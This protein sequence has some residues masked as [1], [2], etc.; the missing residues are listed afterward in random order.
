ME[1]PV[2]ARRLAFGSWIGGDCDGNPNGT[3]QTTLDV[4]ELRTLH[5]L[6]AAA[7]AVDEL[8]SSA[9]IAGT[10]PELDASLVADLE[11]LP[12]VDSR[13][14]CLNAEE[15]YGLTLTCLREKLGRTRN[16]LA[17]EPA[18]ARPRLRRHARF[19]G[20][21]PGQRGEVIARG[22]LERVIHTLATFGLRLAGAFRAMR[23][24][25]ARCMR[26]GRSFRTSSRA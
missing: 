16:R 6:R 12:D 19:A 25:W 17:E 7:E 1:L 23:R 13:Y 24:V 3:P 9:R 18:R 20:P 21:P 22:R 15:H 26:A 2:A 14:L 5:G 11:R 8:S 10:S 4:L